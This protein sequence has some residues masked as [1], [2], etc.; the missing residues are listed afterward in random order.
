MNISGSDVLLDGAVFEII[1]MKNAFEKALDLPP[2]AIVSVTASPAKGMEATVELSEQLADRGYRVIPHLS[3]RLTKT[4]AELE[5][6]VRRL[7][8]AG[9]TRA[10][11]VG[12]D[13]EDPGDFFDAMALI[14]GLGRIE[15]PFTEIGVTGYPE[16]HPFI[17]DD[18]LV[19]ALREKQP[20]ASYIATQMCFD[21]DK[22]RDW[23]T[24][25]RA[26]GIG[27]PVIVG[28]PGAIDTMKLMTIGARIGVGTS[29][30]F[31]AKNRRSVAKLIK[32]GHYTPDEL[33]DDL[34]PMA[35]DPKMSIVG[36]HIF[37]FNQVE[38]TLE[39]LEEARRA[40]P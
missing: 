27:L 28:I 17:D 7:A 20:H 22:I 10:F 40:A 36:L 34:A 11:V 16:G 5:D 24:R 18:L 8:G 38:G 12:G 14:T 13:A 4:Q 3:A 9:I 21:T 35:E 37:T 32:P 6:N 30:K 23:L 25:R 33:I 39:W 29:L 2:R 15:H 1:P 26:E 31:L 19:R